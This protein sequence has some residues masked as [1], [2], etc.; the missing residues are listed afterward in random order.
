[1]TTI[2]Q[3]LAP[4]STEG[5][6]RVDGM[7]FGNSDDG[8][9]EFS[10][11]LD[12]IV[13]ERSRPKSYAGERSRKQDRT[14][15]DDESSVRTTDERQ[16]SDDEMSTQADEQNVASSES[17][18]EDEENFVPLADTSLLVE[19]QILN[20]AAS[21][22]TTTVQDPATWRLNTNEQSQA[23]RV[24]RHAATPAEGASAETP[25]GVMTMAGTQAGG[26]QDTDSALDL[27][28]TQELM[29]PDQIQVETEGGELFERLQ[30]ALA[31]GST[32]LADDVGE[33]VVPQVVRNMAALARN[34]VSEMR[35][36]L[37]P[38]DLGEIELRVRAIEGVVR[39]EVMV[40]HPEVKQLLDSQ[41]DRLRTAL[42]QQGLQLEGFDVGVSDHGSEARGDGDT[43]SD[44]AN[45]ASGI[46]RSDSAE[47]VEDP[48]ISGLPPAH[49]IRLDPNAN[50]WLV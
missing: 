31:T 1:M 44:R 18:T 2:T 8:S 7:N 23:P 48:T 17:D 34:G 30:Q 5:G 38:G 21:G 3:M 43:D 40:Q 13:D 29:A 33:V 46:G 6:S 10:E 22:E 28:T 49:P 26:G 35:L 14:V 11:V 41:M 45:S 15:K 19:P 24:D 16:P 42:A 37:Q 50:D 12:K 9:T 47:D 25:E 32:V 20:D 27:L 36:Q 39:G 4:R